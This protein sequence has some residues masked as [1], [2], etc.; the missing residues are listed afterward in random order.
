MSPIAKKD[1]SNPGIPLPAGIYR[2]RLVTDAVIAKM[3]VWTVEITVHA[4]ECV[5]HVGIAKR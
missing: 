1:V 2:L 5:S 3:D 4:C